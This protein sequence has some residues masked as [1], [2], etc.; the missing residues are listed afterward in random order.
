VK[1]PSVRDEVDSFG[2]ASNENYFRLVFCVDEVGDGFSRVFMQFCGF[3]RQRVNCPVDVGVVVFV[4]VSY[5]VDYLS[6]FLCGCG[7]VKVD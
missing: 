6:G 4:K 5:G 1:A 3:L 7:V 2:C